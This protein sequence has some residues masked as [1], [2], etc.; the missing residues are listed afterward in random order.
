M[1]RSV[2]GEAGQRQAGDGNRNGSANLF[3]FHGFPF[4]FVGL[5]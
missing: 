2:H 5:D 3:Y 1:A 4:Y